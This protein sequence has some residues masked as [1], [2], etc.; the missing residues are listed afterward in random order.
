MK[1][2]HSP[3]EPSAILSRLL[4]GAV[5]NGVRFGVLQILFDRASAIGEP[6]LNLASRWQLFG[7]KPREFPDLSAP[8][9]EPSEQELIRAIELRHKEVAAVEVL[10]PWPHLVITFTDSSVLFVNGKDAQY[11]PWSAGLAHAPRDFQTA[12]IVCPGGEMAFILPQQ[13]LAT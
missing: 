5:V 12:V 3:I 2:S 4:L 11:E 8:A 9:D 10:S 13:Q 6:Y 1:P 7:E